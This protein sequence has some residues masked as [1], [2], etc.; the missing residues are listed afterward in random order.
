VHDLELAETGS[1]LDLSGFVVS[2]VG[3]ELAA[4]WF[5]LVPAKS[6][7]DPTDAGQSA[8]VCCGGHFFGVVKPR[9]GDVHC[10]W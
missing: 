6:V 1:G 4:L 3:G 5:N 10:D 7:S 9:H 8:E 2:S